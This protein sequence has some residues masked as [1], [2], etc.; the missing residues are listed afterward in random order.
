MYASTISLVQVVLT[1]WLPIVLVDEG[2]VKGKRNVYIMGPY[3][4]CTLN[5]TVEGTV[6]LVS[7]RSEHVLEIRRPVFSFLPRV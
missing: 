6:E 5:C 1:E 7:S 3:V 4:I 2:W